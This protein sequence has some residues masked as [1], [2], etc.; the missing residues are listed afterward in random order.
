M[1]GNKMKNKKQHTVGTVSRSNRKKI[2][3]KE[4]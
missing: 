4:N 2:E 1:L 3:K